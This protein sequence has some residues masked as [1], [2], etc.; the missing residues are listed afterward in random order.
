MV[1]A[2]WVNALVG[3]WFIIAPFA[4]GFRDQSGAT[5]LS[6]IGGAILLVLAAWAAMSEEARRQ[7]WIQYVNGLIG[8]WFIVFPFVLGLTARSAVTW[9]SV[10]GGLI[11]L[12]LS[13]W[14][15]F[16]VLPREARA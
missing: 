4:L 5:W 2:N 8:L 11:A 9:T 3:L 16:S 12:V 14:L 13:A 10:I 7:R 1:W 6:I 15:A